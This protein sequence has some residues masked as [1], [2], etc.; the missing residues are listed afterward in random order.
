MNFTCV[1]VGCCCLWFGSGLYRYTERFHVLF[2]WVYKFQRLLS[3][4]V[5]KDWCGGELVC[6]FA[7]RSFG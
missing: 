4:F 2:S 6:Y 5:F 7:L 3:F 1:I